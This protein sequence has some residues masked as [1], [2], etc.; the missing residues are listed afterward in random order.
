MNTTISRFACPSSSLKLRALLRKTRNVLWTGLGLAIVVHI[1]LSQLG[2]FGEEQRV[3]KPLT[4]KFVKRQPRLTKPLEL[5]KRPQPRR[6]PLRRQM[7]SVQAKVATQGS[8]TV[9]QTTQVLRSLAKPRGAL[10]RTTSLGQVELEPEALSRQIIGSKE[11]KDMV[12]MSLEMVDLE[13]L[14]T[15]RHQAMVIQDPN[16]KRNIKGFFHFMVALAPPRPKTVNDHGIHFRTKFALYRLIEKLNEWTQIRA[17]IAKLIDIDSQELF[18]TPWIYLFG[19][20]LTKAELE[21]LGKYILAGGFPVVD[22]SLTI[23]SYWDRIGRDIVNQA[24]ATQGMIQG[25]DWK[26]EIL[27]SSHPI[28]HCYYDF[29]DGPPMT[30]GWRSYQN[31][32]KNTAITVRDDGTRYMEGIILDGRL[33]VLYANLNLTNPWGDWGRVTFGGRDY[34]VHLD[35]TRPLQ[36]GINIVIFALT[37]EGS[38]TNRIMDTV[39]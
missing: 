25:K 16:D 37:Q 21:N 2:S 27:P 7:I 30:D 33:A 26:Y 1:I 17:D 29:L 5:K 10:H 34:Y 18:K 36:F 3:A 4:T 23:D 8:R 38:I 13:A 22:G 20:Y 32:Q 14:D 15:G 35:P 9:L 11:S 24:F 12:D 28:Y 19:V 6:R 31:K 39:R